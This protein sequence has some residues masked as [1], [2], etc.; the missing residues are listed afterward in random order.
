[1]KTVIVNSYDTKWISWTMKKM[2]IQATLGFCDT[3]MSIRFSKTSMIEKRIVGET[4]IRI[5]NKMLKTF[6]INKKIIWTKHPWQL[7]QQSLLNDI[8]LL[9]HQTSLPYFVVILFVIWLQILFTYTSH[10]Q[11][12]S[13]IYI[14]FTEFGIHQ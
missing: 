13:I 3:L 14:F 1:M 10:F 7:I 11:H 5:K 9:D 12:N 4:K 8:L 6:S 2:W